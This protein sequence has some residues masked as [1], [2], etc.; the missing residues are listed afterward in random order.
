MI[1]LF[2][3]IG[4]AILTLFYRCTSSITFVLAYWVILSL[5]LRISGSHFNP[6]L[7]LAFMFR[8]TVGRFSRKLGILYMLFQLGGGLSGALLAWFFYRDTSEPS[9]SNKFFQQSLGESI[10]SFFFILLFLIQTE[11][12]QKFS[13]QP[14]I[15]TLV[16]SAG[17]LICRN[18]SAAAGMGFVNPAAAF[19]L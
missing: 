14:A 17:F 12:N 15:F 19:G 3:F 2:E 18:I 10:A 6:A 5:C 11:P 1:L 16:I 7:T 8:K 4:T 9:V 13:N